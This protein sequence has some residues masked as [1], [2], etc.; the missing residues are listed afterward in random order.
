MG[1]VSWIQDP[2]SWILGS[3]RGSWI[4]D[5]E[6]WIQ[7]KHCKEMPDARPYNYKEMPGAR[8]YNYKEMPGFRPY[9]YKG[10]FLAVSSGPIPG[11][12][13]CAGVAPPAGGDTW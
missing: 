6:S 10:D 4:Q 2:G 1:P 13:F 9:N 12:V 3:D 11:T 7:S 5:P 8:P